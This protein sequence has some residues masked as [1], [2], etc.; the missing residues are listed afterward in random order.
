MSPFHEGAGGSDVSGRS[1]MNSLRDLTKYFWTSVPQAVCGAPLGVPCKG[2]DC[3]LPEPVFLSRVGHWIL[4]LP[5]TM[6][7][8]K[9]STLSDWQFLAV[10][11]E[12]GV[13]NLP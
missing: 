2:S 3:R 13:I 9:A 11:F 1:H 5:G 8:E 4:T 6:V 7:S 12:H 10:N